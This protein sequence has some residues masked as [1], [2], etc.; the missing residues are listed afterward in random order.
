MVIYEFHMVPVT[1]LY[2]TVEL[3]EATGFISLTFRGP[4]KEWLVCNAKIQ[5]E[6]KRLWYNVDKDTLFQTDCIEWS[7]A[8]KESN[9]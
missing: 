2:K 1:I 4:W 7:S 5:N 8:K 9:S 3:G 6:N